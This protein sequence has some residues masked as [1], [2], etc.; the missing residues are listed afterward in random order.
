[1]SIRKCLS[2]HDLPQKIHI[3]SQKR[4]LKVGFDAF[5]R[6]ER[7]RIGIGKHE[8]FHALLNQLKDLYLN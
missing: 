2:F 3:L 6:L 4:V 7:E 5:E 8:A 1:M